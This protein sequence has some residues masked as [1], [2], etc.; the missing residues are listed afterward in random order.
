MDSWNFDSGPEHRE[1]P[2]ADGRL[3][4]IPT[5]FLLAAFYCHSLL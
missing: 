1:I 3:E 2:K 4:E 5:G